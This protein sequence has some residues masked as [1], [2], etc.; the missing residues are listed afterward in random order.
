M[1]ESGGLNICDLA[2]K[3]TL[4]RMNAPR[5]KWSMNEKWLG[6]RITGPLAGTF[7]DEIQRARKAIHPH[8]EVIARTSSYIGSGSR[9]RA[10]S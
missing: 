1:N 10:R 8:I 5:K 3:R 4:R 6:A 2:M 9:V 7:S